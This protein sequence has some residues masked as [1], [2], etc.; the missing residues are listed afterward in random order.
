MRLHE[1]LE[2]EEFMWKDGESLARDPTGIPQILP[3][4][5]SHVPS[6]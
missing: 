6:K 2:K 3:P 4:E 5:S 1:Q